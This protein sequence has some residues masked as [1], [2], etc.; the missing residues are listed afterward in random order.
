M[1]HS[2]SIDSELL[3][4]LL[5]R[6]A[7]GDRPAFT[8]LYRLSA[9]KLFGLALRI[10]KTRALA[11]EALQ[12]AFVR[13]WRHA[14]E[15]RPDRGQAFTWMASILRHHSLDLIRRSGREMQADDTLFAA[16]PDERAEPALA[17]SQAR[18]AQALRNCLQTLEADQRQSLLLAYYDGMTHVELAAR[19][20]QPLGTVKSW[21]R[22]GL[23]RLRRCLE[24]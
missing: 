5:A 24:Q 22:R 16:V 23:E 4:R 6:C 14:A 9:P 10:L 8:E 2:T 19:L 13:V 17:W 21:I 12:E 15:Y 1:T 11:E 3:T 7:L 20:R 18:E